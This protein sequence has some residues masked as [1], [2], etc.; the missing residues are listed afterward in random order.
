MASSRLIVANQSVEEPVS[1]AKVKGMVDA[2]I[3][4]ASKG[5]RKI[6]RKLSGRQTD[7][8]NRIILY[9][10]DFEL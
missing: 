5:G 4:K 3:A 10:K 6:G 1:I 7:R 9:E 2:A 8:M